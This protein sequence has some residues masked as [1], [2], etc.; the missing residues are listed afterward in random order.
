MPFPDLSLEDA[1]RTFDAPWQ[2]Q[3]FALVIK[4]H[5]DGHFTWP[6]F[7]ERLAAVIRHHE[8][9]GI[10]RNYYQNWHDAA[11]SLLSERGLIERDD[12]DDSVQAVIA[13]QASDHGHEPHKTP[14]AIAPA[15]LGDLP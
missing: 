15:A 5:E 2:A 10:E 6:A 4:L 12:L 1:E 8:D 11:V 3:I 7:S 9:Q 14:I 13:H